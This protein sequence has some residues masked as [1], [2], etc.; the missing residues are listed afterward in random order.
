MQRTDIF[1]LFF[2]DDVYNL[3]VNESTKYACFF[4]LSDPK[5]TCQELKCFLAILTRLVLVSGYNILP[6][7]KSYW[8]GGD[9]MRNTLVYNAMRRDRFIQMMRFMHAAD[10]S[11]LN[12][13]DKMSKLRPLMNLLKE[14]FLHHLPKEQHLNYDESMI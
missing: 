14:K 1:E 2:D 5:I 8:D 10:N 11:N 7:K 9:D 4:N 6:S 13:N 3:L 12:I